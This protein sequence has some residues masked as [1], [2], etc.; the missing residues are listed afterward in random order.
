MGFSCFSFKTS[1]FY[2]CEFVEHIYEYINETGQ[3]PV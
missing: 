1:I 3:K 2:M